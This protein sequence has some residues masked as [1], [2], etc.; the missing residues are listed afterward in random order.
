ME[1]SDFNG[2]AFDEF[3]GTIQA[4]EALRRMMTSAT[5]LELKQAFDEYLAIL[6]SSG[7]VDLSMDELR[8]SKKTGGIA[9]AGGAD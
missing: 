2:S 4:E 5:S 3:D 7:L 9:L 6:D 1:I 8:N